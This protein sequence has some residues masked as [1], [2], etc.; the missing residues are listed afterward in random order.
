MSMPILFLLACSGDASDDSGSDALSEGPYLSDEVDFEAP[1]FDASSVSAAVDGALSQALAINAV[2]VVTI[3]SAF[4]DAATADCP[5]WTTYEDLPV[6]VDSCTTADG[7]AFEGYG[8]MIEYDGMTD[9]DGTTYSGYQIS[10]VSSM[11]APDGSSLT[12]AGSA[13]LLYGVNGAYEVFYTNVSEGTRWAGGV[14]DSWLDWGINPSMYLYAL[15]D[16]ASGARSIQLAGSVSIDDGGVSAVVFD[17]LYLI[18][19][20]SGTVCSAEPSG[21]ISILSSEGQ[22]YD[23]VFDGPT[24]DNDLV[25]DSLCDGCATAWFKGES[26]GEACVDFSVLTDWDDNPWGL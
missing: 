19:D 14:T 22:W 10:S 18:D 23:L 13:D 5:Q 17:D 3:Y 16:T 6:W 20:P 24:E 1:A 25:P 8:L 9:A 26:L 15:R 2:P 21:M 11:A 4:M 12:I 7:I